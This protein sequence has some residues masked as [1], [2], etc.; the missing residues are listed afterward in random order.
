MRNYLFGRYVWL[1]EY[2]RNHKNVKYSDVANAWLRESSLNPDG[3]PF[4]ARTFH[5]HRE[6]IAD[7][8][9][10]DIE[11]DSSTDTYHIPCLDQMNDTRNWLLDSY[12]TLNQLKADQSLVGRIIFEDIPSGRQWL[13]SITN[14]MR[15]NEVILIDYHNLYEDK[16]S[17]AQIEPYALKVSRRRWYV[18]AKNKEHGQYRN[19][20]LDRIDRITPTGK[21]FTAD[22]K[23]NIDEYFEGCCGIITDM[24]KPVEK[25]LIA[26]YGNFANYMRALPIHTS[27]TELPHT[28]DD[29]AANRTRFQLHV[30]TTLDFYQQVLSFGNQVRILAPLSAVKQLSAMANSIAALYQAEA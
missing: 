23:F 15:N 30:R 3:E 22:K 29:V 26:A 25:V 1:I 6:A 13:P 27:Q 4:P 14:A 5:R 12:A 21:K 2:I 19:Y 16:V 9:G 24:A 10:V 7:I 28:E 8:F 17:R 11:C 18:V 20:A